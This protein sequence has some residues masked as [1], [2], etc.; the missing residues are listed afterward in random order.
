MLPHYR[1]PSDTSDVEWFLLG[2]LPSIPAC[3]TLSFGVVEFARRG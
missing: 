1:Y 2:P 3:Q